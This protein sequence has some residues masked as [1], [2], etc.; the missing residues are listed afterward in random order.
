MNTSW[1]HYYLLEPYLWLGLGGLV[2]LLLGLL[3]IGKRMAYVCAVIVLLGSLFSAMAL[4]SHHTTFGDGHFILITPFTQLCLIIFNSVAICVVLIS[5]SY[6]PIA[7]TLNEIYYSLIVFSVLG[8]A[9]IPSDHLMAVMLGI[10]IVTVCSF[11]LIIWHPGRVG[12]IEAAMKYVVMAGVATAFLLMGVALIYLGSGTLTVS[13]IASALTNSKANIIWVMVG[14]SLLFVGIGFD[15]ALVPFH[16]WL[17]DVYQGAPPPVVA[18]ISSVAKIA[19]LAWLL[20]LPQ[21]LSVQL[22]EFLQLMVVG[23]GVS[24]MIVGMFLALQQRQLKRLFAYSSIVHFGFML[25]AFLYDYVDRTSVII[26]YALSYVVTIVCVWTVLIIIE[27]RSAPLVRTHY[28]GLGYR[29]PFLGLVLGLALLSFAGVPP[30]PGFFAKWLL[31]RLSIHYENWWLLWMMVTV[32]I[33]SLYY[34]FRVFCTLFSKSSEETIVE[35]SC[36]RVDA[37]PA[38]ILIVLLTSVIVMIGCLPHLILRYVDVLF[39]S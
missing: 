27:K 7:H 35:N 37:Y 4:F 10:E 13:H 16:G 20:L 29:Y 23:M 18:L 12:A 39:F 1:E 32:S 14:F 6:L 3:P 28:E 22:W 17:A 8:M 11:G 2:V 34:Y 38:Y 26:Y 30:L 19:V 21:W 33:V 31:F 5:R 24:S 36:L 15:L 9:L 25:V